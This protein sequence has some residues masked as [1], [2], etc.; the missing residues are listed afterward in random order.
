M[1]NCPNCGAPITS[2]K[3]EYCGT[4]FHTQQKIDDLTIKVNYLANAKMRE[5]LYASAIA[6][7]R[8]SCITPNEC[9]RLI[10][11]QT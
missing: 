8:S 1:I 9:R 6:A 11:D 2:D 10:Y 7:M 3:C 4:E 5:E